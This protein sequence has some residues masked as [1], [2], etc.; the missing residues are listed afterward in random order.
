MVQDK[1]SSLV[2]GLHCL[3]KGLLKHFSICQKQTAFVVIGGLYST[4]YRSSD[5]EQGHS[6]SSKY[7]G[8]TF[9]RT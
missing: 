5:N 2:W 9:K 7:Y 1:I 8:I 4:E 6:F 3:A